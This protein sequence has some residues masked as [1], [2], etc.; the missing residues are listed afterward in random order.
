MPFDGRLSCPDG[1]GMTDW[2]CLFIGSKVESHAV[3]LQGQNWRVQDF[4]GD[5]INLTNHANVAYPVL[6]R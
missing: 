2:F 4:L 1:G 3:G 6:P 5:V